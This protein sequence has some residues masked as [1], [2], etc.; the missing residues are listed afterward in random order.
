MFIAT[1][2]VGADTNETLF[3]TNGPTCTWPAF[4][5]SIEMKRVDSKSRHRLFLKVVSKSIL[6]KTFGH[7]DKKL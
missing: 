6:K 2:G 7:K 4:C 5:I 3:S 1:S